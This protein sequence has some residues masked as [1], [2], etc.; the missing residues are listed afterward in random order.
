[1]CYRNSSNKPA[2]ALENRFSAGFA[3]EINYKPTY[4]ASAFDAHQWAVVT[5]ENPDTIHTYIWGI[6]PSWVKDENQA[7]ELQAGNA[8][9]RCETV[10]EKPSFRESIKRKRCLVVSTGFY[11]FKEV[12]GK[13]YPYLIRSFESEIFTF[14]GIYADWVDKSTGELFNT[15]A[16]LTKEADTFMADIHNTK[17]RMPIILPEK[18]E[19]NWL[20]PGLEKNEIKS[21]AL[22]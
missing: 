21:A 14:A 1:M 11:E 12:K 6:I 22:T 8:N 2:S 9:A 3:S 20:K 15:F 16:V 5:Q 17:K 19:K 4:H 18:E 10:F 7:I 13:K